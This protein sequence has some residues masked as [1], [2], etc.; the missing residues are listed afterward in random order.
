MLN[1]NIQ[2]ISTWKCR[3]TIKPLPDP[4]YR[5]APIDY[6]LDKYIGLKSFVGYAVRTIN[7]A[8]HQSSKGTHSVPYL[9]NPTYQAEQLRYFSYLRF[10]H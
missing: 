3:A 9:A 5:V 4:A 1:N 6:K 2:N 10:N 8:Q 7:H